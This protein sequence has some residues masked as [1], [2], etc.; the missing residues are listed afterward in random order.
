MI[1]F[2]IINILFSYFF[3]KG[4]IK[5]NKIFNKLLKYYLIFLI[6]FKLFDFYFFPIKINYLYYLISIFLPFIFYYFKIWGAGDSKLL[7]LYFLILPNFIVKKETYFYIVK[8]LNFLFIF[9]FS[10]YFIIGIYG[11]LK[12]KSILFN[13]IEFKENIYFLLLLTLSLNIFNNFFNFSNFYFSLLLNLIFMF[14]I[15]KFYDIFFRKY[16]I[17]TIIFL[18]LGNIQLKF[19]SIALKIILTFGIFIS[20]KIIRISECKIIP[21]SE[22]SLGMILSENTLKKF[23][24]SRVRGLPNLKNNDLNYKIQNIEEIEAINRWKNSKYGENT[25][26]IEKTIPFSIYICITY[27]ISLIYFYL[28]K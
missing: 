1:V 24:F 2:L 21:I 11:I 20:R 26:E 28:K 4:D 22:L 13:K 16:K 9:S 17:L 25:I 14:F 19:S 12:N 15:K 3:I 8:Y 7:T 18:I 6:I 27:L 10:I 23:S 5:E